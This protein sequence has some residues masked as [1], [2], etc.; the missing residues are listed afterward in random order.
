MILK[1]HS[2]IKHLSSDALAFKPSIG[3]RATLRVTCAARWIL[4]ARHEE[5]QSGGALPETWT[6]PGQPR[7]TFGQRSRDERTPPTWLSTTTP[8][9]LFY[10]SFCSC[11]HAHENCDVSLHLHI[12]AAEASQLHLCGLDCKPGGPD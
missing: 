7:Y 11:C 1:D 8:N 6:T 10:C 3:L 12:K 5:Q 4:R 2:V 9:V